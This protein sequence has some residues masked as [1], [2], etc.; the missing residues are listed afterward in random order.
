MLDT[1]TV[2]AGDHLPIIYPASPFNITAPAAVG[3]VTMPK[4]Y[5]HYQRNTG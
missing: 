1:N 2:T 4:F 5:H 3:G